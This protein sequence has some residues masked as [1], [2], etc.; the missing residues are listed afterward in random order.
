M[1][2]SEVKPTSGAATC[3]YGPSPAATVV[4]AVR[5]SKEWGP[6]QEGKAGHRGSR[7]AD[8]SA[9][10]GH[11]FHGDSH[12][13]AAQALAA[14]PPAL[15]RRGFGVPCLPGCGPCACRK[16][17]GMPPLA[18]SFQSIYKIPGLA[19]PFSTASRRTG[20]T[21]GACPLPFRAVAAGA[22][23]DDPLH[24]KGLN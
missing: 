8:D 19:L 7:H 11:S 2:S 24:A 9:E 13:I 21:P 20:P 6:R 14:C 17:G 5:L 10:E 12:A 1:V 23:F 22:G 4:S 18:E 16:T 3:L 15:P